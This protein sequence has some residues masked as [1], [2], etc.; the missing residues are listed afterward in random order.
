MRAL[1]LMHN[2]GDGLKRNWDRA[3]ETKNKKNTKI[4]WFSYYKMSQVQ[5]AFNPIRFWFSS[6]K[7]FHLNILF[8]S[9]RMR[10]FHSQITNRSMQQIAFIF[11]QF[12]YRSNYSAAFHRIIGEK[13][14]FDSFNQCTLWSPV[15]SPIQFKRNQLSI[16]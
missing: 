5:L 11:N 6:R 14:N 13:R 3:R 7:T 9:Y 10:V 1:E 15:S 8:Y 2:V 16:F 4:G 12:R